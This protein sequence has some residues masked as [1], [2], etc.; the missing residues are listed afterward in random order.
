MDA[1]K[2]QMLLPSLVTAEVL[3]AVT[4]TTTVFWNMTFFV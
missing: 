1:S 4:M 2:T 3:K